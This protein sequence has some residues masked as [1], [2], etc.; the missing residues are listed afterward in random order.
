MS[1]IL[2]E[3]GWI[4]GQTKGPS[5]LPS[6]SRAL[7]HSAYSLLTS[8][9]AVFSPALLSCWLPRGPAQ[10]LAPPQTGLAGR[11]SMQQQPSSGPQ[12]LLTLP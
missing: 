3:A 12:L 5:A 7:I 1:A 9:S 11:G 10:P 4:D 8:P 6:G 2:I